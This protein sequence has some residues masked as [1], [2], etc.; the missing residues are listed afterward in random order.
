M[1]DMTMLGEAQVRRDLARLLHAAVE[2]S[3]RNRCEIAREADIHKDALRR[4]LC[5]ERSPSLG[6]ALR[7]LASAGMAPHAHML[8]FLGAGGDHAT[9]WLQTEIAKFFEELVC[10]LP[11]ALERILGN[12]ILEVKPRW[13][14]G[15]AH[16]VARL[17]ADHIDELE[18][19]DALL[20][21]I[22]AATVGGRHD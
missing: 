4:T 12:Q 11:A 1:I 17:L 8:L 7:I 3:G 16:R 14:K 2:L 6:E 5:G 19:K 22:F 20:G 21:D 9:R 15:T 10:E 13:A 18:R